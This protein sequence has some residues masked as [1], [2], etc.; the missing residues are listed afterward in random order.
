MMMQSFFN[1]VFVFDLDDTLYSEREYVRSCFAKID[2]MVESNYG[3]RGSRVSLEHWFQAGVSAPI[4]KL[5]ETR[6]LP[7]SDLPEAIDEVRKHIPSIHLF[8]DAAWLLTRLRCADRPFAIVT[9]GRSITQRAKLQALNCLDADFVSISEETGLLKTDARRF[10]EVSNY[11]GSSD[12]IYI[13]DNPAK[14]F[15]IPNLLGW[16]T[17]MRIHQ[18][19]LIHDQTLSKDLRMHPSIT[20]HSF[21]DFF[22]E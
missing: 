13:G 4:Q 22:Q 6:G 21:K 15:L 10:L 20:V 5:W 12:Y 1:T 9:D 8:D 14:D 17:V 3:I 7:S 18:P 19:P 2:Q 16:K 11:F